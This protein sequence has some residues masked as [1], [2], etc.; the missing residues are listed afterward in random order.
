MTT[1]HKYSEKKIWVEVEVNKFTEGITVFRGLIAKAD[2]EAWSRGELVDCAIRLES[3]YWFLEDSLCVLGKGEDNA[4]HYTGEVY[5]RA[6]TVMLIFP[7]RDDS[8][9]TEFNT[10]VDNIFLFPGRAPTTPKVNT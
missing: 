6:D 2:L 8:F 1:K 7:L 10:I 3:T 9:P 4:R 5:L